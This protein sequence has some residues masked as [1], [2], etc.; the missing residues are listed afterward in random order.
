MD[1]DRLYL[2]HIVGAI[3]RIKQYTEGITV[4]DF[5]R[6]ALFKM[7]LSGNLKLLVKPRG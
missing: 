5:K 2:Q 4:D 6:G 7:A 1:K 3:K